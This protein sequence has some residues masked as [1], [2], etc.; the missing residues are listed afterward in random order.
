[1]SKGHAASALYAALANRGFFPR[2]DLFTHG[3]TGSPFEE[4]PGLHSPPGVDCVSGSL[5]HALP[6]SLGLAKSALLKGSK[7]KFAVLMGDGELNE[8]SIWEAAMFAST[9]KLHNLTA[10]I[11]VNQWQGT[12]RSSSVMNI[13]PLRDKWEAFGWH[14]LEVDGHNHNEI[15]D[16]LNTGSQIKN[17]PTVVIANTI[18]GKG[19]SFME[20]DNNW[21]Y[22]IPNDSELRAALDELARDESLIDA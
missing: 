1:L 15:E 18:K 5:G 20:D 19:I 11:D 14:A 21:H 17:K 4:H 13:L 12:G 10:I 2:E 22:R 3:Q 16:A 6:I 8:G 7:A 9:H